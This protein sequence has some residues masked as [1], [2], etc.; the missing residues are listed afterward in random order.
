MRERV[1]MVGGT[2]KSDSTPGKGTL[3]SAEIP[4]SY[5]APAEARK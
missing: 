5:G 4:F 3:V 1:E 2:F